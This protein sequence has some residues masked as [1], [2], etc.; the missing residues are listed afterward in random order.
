MSPVVPTLHTVS[1]TPEAKRFSKASV[2]S[3]PSF[4]DASPVSTTSPSART[5]DSGHSAMFTA[6]GMDDDDALVS[7]TGHMNLDRNSMSSTVTHDDGKTTTPHKPDRK[8]TVS[9]Y[10]R[11]PNNGEVITF[12]SADDDIESEFVMPGQFVPGGAKDV[13]PMPSEPSRARGDSV[14]DLYYTKTGDD[15][16]AARAQPVSDNFKNEVFMGQR[17]VTGYGFSDATKP[18]TRSPRIGSTSNPI[19]QV[20]AGLN[21]RMSM[22]SNVGDPTALK[23]MSDVSMVSR[24]QDASAH[25]PS[26]KGATPGFSPDMDKRALFMEAR[27]AKLEEHPLETLLAHPRSEQVSRAQSDDE[28][29]FSSTQ[30]SLHHPHDAVT[31]SPGGVSD[32]TEEHE[33]AHEQLPPNVELNEEG[34]PVQIVYYD[35][36]ELP[37]IMDRIASGSNSARIEFR[38]RSAYPVQ[39]ARPSTDSEQSEARAPTDEESNLTFVEQSILTLLRPTF[40]LKMT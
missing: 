29:S 28:H 22:Y 36:D 7:E 16:T 10:I 32:A 27:S 9:M 12:P 31:V 35:D 19:W 17:P 37:E 39:Q 5:R 15:D 26:S 38:R 20:V 21:E 30:D 24:A 6:N 40:S 25:V 1:K 8:S 14:Y 11:D 4:A 2:L 23:R 3:T 33:D 34:Q 13:P 18:N